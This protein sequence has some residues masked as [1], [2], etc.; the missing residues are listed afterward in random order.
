MFCIIT[1]Q[2]EAN[3]WLT[4]VALDHLLR[5]L[6]LVTY[7]SN[8]W[9]GKQNYQF[10]NKKVI[11]FEYLKNSKLKINKI[12]VCLGH[13]NVSI[14]SLDSLAPLFQTNLSCLNKKNCLVKLKNCSCIFMSYAW[15]NTLGSLCQCFCLFYSFFQCQI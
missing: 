10:C 5:K 13:T 3:V 11:I 6:I 2:T 12:F 7:A 14:I 9:R 8:Q 15:T 4:S 1:N